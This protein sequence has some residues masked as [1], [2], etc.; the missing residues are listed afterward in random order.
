MSCPLY[1]GGPLFGGSV[2]VFPTDSVT[3]FF[4]RFIALSTILAVVL[5]CCVFSKALNLF[6]TKIVCDHGVENHKNLLSDNYF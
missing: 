2:I 5:K 6:I 3:N 1:R 4:T